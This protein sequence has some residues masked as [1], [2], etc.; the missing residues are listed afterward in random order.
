M[1]M[2]NLGDAHCGEGALQ[3]QHTLFL[4]SCCSAASYCVVS[5]WPVAAA[6]RGGAPW[7]ASPGPPPTWPWK[8]LRVL[9]SVQPS[10]EIK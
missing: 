2:P 9:S 5:V 10:K 1:K 8:P 6:G 7:T 4:G 3:S